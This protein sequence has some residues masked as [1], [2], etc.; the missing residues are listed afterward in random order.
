M[1]REHIVIIGLIA[2]LGIQYVRTEDTVSAFGV[3]GF[4]GLVLG[5]V[6]GAAWVA[7]E[8]P[9]VRREDD[10]PDFNRDTPPS[11][12]IRNPGQTE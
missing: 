5:I 2:L 3:G 8:P 4:V 1:T 10:F 12:L 7:G 6:L 9:R 11:F